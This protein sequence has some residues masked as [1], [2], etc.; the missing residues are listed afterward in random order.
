MQFSSSQRYD[1]LTQVLE[2]MHVQVW[3]QPAERLEAAALVS[4]KQQAAGNSETCRGQ[5]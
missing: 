3:L 1:D 5:T 2:A 4:A